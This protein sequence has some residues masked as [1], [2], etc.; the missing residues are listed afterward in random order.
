MGETEHSRKCYRI[1]DLTLDTGTH[2]LTRGD[3]HIELP[4][5]SYRLLMLLVDRAPAVVMQDEIAERI[6]AGRVVSPETITQRVKLLRQALGDDARH[7]RYIALI[8]G[9]GY[10]LLPDVQAVENTA[11]TPHGGPR[12]SSRRRSAILVLGL[13]V[14]AVTALAYLPGLL[15]TGGPD[16]PGHAERIPMEKSV[17]VLPF[18]DMSADG[19]ATY[20]GDGIAD[21]VL[22]RL[23]QSGD[24]LVIART[25]SFAL[26]DA[27]L[28]IPAIA[29]RLG[30]RYVLQG[31]VR[32]AGGTVRVTAQLVDVRQN[33]QIWSEAYERTLEDV[34]SVQQD[35]AT[36]IGDV[37]ELHLGGPDPQS[38]EYDPA[39]YR[40]YLRGQFFWNRRGAGDVARAETSYRQALDIDPTLAPAW[41]GMA[42][43]AMAGFYDEGRGSLAATRQAQ[44]QALERALALDPNLAEA[45]ARM[46]QLLW[47]VGEY[48]AGRRHMQRARELAPNSPL[49]LVLDAGYRMWT[50]DLDGSIAL[51]RR[52]IA[53]NPLASSY[54]YN[55]GLTLILAGRADEGL[56]ELNQAIALNPA[57][58]P[59]FLIALARL[60]QGRYEEARSLVDEFA[61]PADRHA[62]DAIALRELG[63]EAA[64]ANA[65]Q[66]LESLESARAI[67]QTAHVKAWFGDTEAPF[68][69]LEELKR[70]TRQ[71][72]ETIPEA[73]DVLMTLV[74]LRFA[75]Y[76][77][78]AH[79]T[80]RWQESIES[81]AAQWHDAVDDAASP[82]ASPDAS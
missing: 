31:S 18:E 50:G 43:V 40:H 30:V 33:T 20:L 62:V 71:R 42:A 25:S 66:E 55:L 63:Q 1:G 61:Y 9:Q 48:A 26:R 74:K 56:T 76:L 12:A 82:G 35:I 49:I 75:P 15:T 77:R 21:E 6:W 8:R 67:L 53:V 54:H 65:M 72:P 36:A 78:G 41:V 44:R 57:L 27:G 58:N 60:H 13:A 46:C 51:S 4:P 7:P 69:A 59:A 52:A 37:L 64:A 19:D 24:L 16:G 68:R 11:G 22:H 38:G 79:S 32:Q 81:V 5:L 23:N 73:D 3:E 34:L 14:V 29:A 80:E 45:H 70:L 47:S 17:A 39:A 10:R 2:E 28:D